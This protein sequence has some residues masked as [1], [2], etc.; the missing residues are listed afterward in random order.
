[1]VSTR[2][3]EPYLNGRN[4]PPQPGDGAEGTWSRD[5]LLQMDARFIARVQRAIA[6][7]EEHAATAKRNPPA[8]E[9][10]R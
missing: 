3:G 5:E 2:P 9:G 8:G 1:V 4:T 6:R 10:S 7:G